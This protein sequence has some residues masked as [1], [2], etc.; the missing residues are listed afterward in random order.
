MKGHTHNNVA[1]RFV[2]YQDKVPADREEFD[3]QLKAFYASKGFTYTVP[4][5]EGDEM[6]FYFIFKQV[7]E[8]GGF[9]AV[10]V[11][12][13]RPITTVQMLS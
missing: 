11:Q 4:V 2:D 3:R 9:E 7:A 5:V 1:R 8:R 12:R 13:C 6:D 10:V